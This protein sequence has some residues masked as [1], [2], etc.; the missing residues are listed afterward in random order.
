MLKTSQYIQFFKF[1]YH[2]NHTAYRF[3]WYADEFFARHWA[4]IGHITKFSPKVEFKKKLFNSSPFSSQAKIK[5]FLFRRLR[6]LYFKFIDICGQIPEH[7][8]KGDSLTGGH[9]D[10]SIIIPFTIG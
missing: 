3:P 6:D 5:Q 10:I 7:N 4:K 1:M 2:P 8:R 9:P